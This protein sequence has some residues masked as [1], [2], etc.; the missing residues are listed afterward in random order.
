M[1]LLP[2]FVWGGSFI[3]TRLTLP[4]V[5]PFS[6]A[7]IR[8]G[9]GLIFLLGL[10]TALGGRV[11]RDWREWPPIMGLG[12]CNSSAF[13]LTAWGQLFIP[14]GLTTI[15]AATIPFFTIIVAH[16]V[17]KDD[18]INTGRAFGIFLGLIGVVILVGFEALSDMTQGIQGQLA[19]LG[20]SFLYGVAGVFARPVLARQSTNNG[21]TWIP[22]VRVMAMQ[23][24]TS[25]TI[26]T[27]IALISDQ[28]WTLEIPLYILGYLAMMGVGVTAF[29]TLTFYYLIESFGPSLAS[30][31]MYIIPISGVTLGVFVLGEQLTWT[32]PVAALFILGGVFIANRPK[33]HRPK[34]AS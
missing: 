19:I 31:T 1:I 7:L 23:M 28:T 20:A 6:L 3:L 30:M 14:G 22:R 9:M 16:F 32:M 15:L 8:N 24:I 4:F 18:R 2:G 17:T 25:V 12:I 33:S 26:L 10:L 34:L 27:P 29:A 5:P 11:H 13:L 21:S